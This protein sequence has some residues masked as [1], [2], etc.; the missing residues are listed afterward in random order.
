[1]SRTHRYKLGVF[2]CRNVQNLE[3]STETITFYTSLTLA[4]RFL[5]ISVCYL[6]CLSV[7]IIIILSPT[8]L[9]LHWKLELNL[10]DEHLVRKSDDKRDL[11]EVEGCSLGEL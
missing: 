4:L 2:Q 11:A 9:L 6:H 8:I 5:G 7:V 1:M 10:L 3:I